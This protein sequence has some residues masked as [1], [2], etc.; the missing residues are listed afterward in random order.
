MVTS[1]YYHSEYEKTGYPVLKGRLAPAYAFLQKYIREHCSQAQIAFIEPNPVD[2]DLL[3]MVHTEHHIG[4]V[5]ASGFY[6]SAILSAGAAV[7]GAAGVWKGKFDNTFVFTGT[8]GHHASRDHAWGFCYFNNTALALENLRNFGLKRFTVVDTDPHPGDGTQ[9]CLEGTRGFQHFNF[10][11]Y[12]TIS[13]AGEIW[14]IG[15][16]SHCDDDSF[17]LAVEAIEPEIIRFSPEILVWN[18]GHD[19]HVDDYGGFHLSLHAFPRICERL[20]K[21]ADEICNSRFL[22]FLSGGSEAYVAKYSIA[23]VVG[24]LSG[25]P[26]LPSIPEDPTD[27]NDRMLREVKGILREL[28]LS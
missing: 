13:K 24:L 18:I 23:S 26:T 21:I 7:E 2:L 17:L 15:L 14:D 27:P 5:K 1:V 22:V 3:K 28:G 12:G 4:S 16:P 19:A 25:C 11:S 9:D 8:A 10:Q 20:L 6:P